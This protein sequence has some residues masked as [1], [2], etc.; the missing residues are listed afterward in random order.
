MDGQNQ[1]IF[2]NFQERVGGLPIP[3][4]RVPDM[5]DFIWSSTS[6]HKTAYATVKALV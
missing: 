5:K 6:N 1:G 3:P 2:F 4:S